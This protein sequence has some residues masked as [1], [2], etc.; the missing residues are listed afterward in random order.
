M[1]SCTMCH[2]MLRYIR[3]CLHADFCTN[4][5]KSARSSAASSTEEEEAKD[6]AELQPMAN[7]PRDDVINATGL[8][9]T[10]LLQMVLSTVSPHVA[11][12]PVNPLACCAAMLHNHVALA[13]KQAD[14]SHAAQPCCIG[15]KAS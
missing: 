8:V 12:D 4:D 15:C 7:P 5:K 9:M 14:S 6:A 13:A 10:M 2:T 11:H 1:A 3:G